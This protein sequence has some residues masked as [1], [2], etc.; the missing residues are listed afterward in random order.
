M[1]FDMFGSPE[2]GKDGDFARP[3]ASAQHFSREPL[4]IQRLAARIISQKRIE[5]N[6]RNAQ[7]STGPKTAHGKSRS[8]F[9]ALKF[10][11]FAKQSL[12]IGECSEEHADLVWHVTRELAPKT[13]IESALVDQIVSDL[14]R[15]TRV[16]Q[17]ARAYFEQV[18]ESACARLLRTL[19]P[20]DLRKIKDQY[21]KEIPPPSQGTTDSSPEILQNSSLLEDK[22]IKPVD[23]AAG[24]SSAGRYHADARMDCLEDPATV[25]LEAI[26][27]PHQELP[28]A[29]LER[30]RSQ[31]LRGILQKNACLAKLRLQ[32]CASLRKYMS[33][34]TA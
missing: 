23:S 22:P 29:S 13:I 20:K 21:S 34:V 28:F 8:R 26:V 1:N 11:A 16:E 30:I 3:D 32:Q 33:R 7:K 19:P 12:I 4:E 2:T 24:S 14:W 18:Q 15:L 25:L 31:L 10:G 6:R 27:D 5:S 17:A 9:N